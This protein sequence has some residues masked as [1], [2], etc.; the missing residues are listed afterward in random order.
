M[1]IAAVGEGTSKVMQNELGKV[2]ECVIPLTSF[3]SPSG[4]EFLS[5]IVDGWLC[6]WVIWEGMRGTPSGR[7]L[8][9]V[10]GLLD[11]VFEDR[12]FIGERS[13]GVERELQ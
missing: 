13:S 6:R 9:G 12:S 11:I 8:R 5:F 1:A 7:I 4:I 3:F 2:V 10:I